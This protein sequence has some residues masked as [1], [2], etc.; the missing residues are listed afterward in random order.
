MC[1]HVIYV[2]LSTTILFVGGIAEGEVSH[3]LF[4]CRV[5]LHQIYYSCFNCQS[6]EDK[7]V[8]LNV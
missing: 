1:L 6:A 2:N 8:T 4:H 7:S 5:G 3:F